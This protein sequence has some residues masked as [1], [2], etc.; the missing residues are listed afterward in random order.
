MK[1]RS[2]PV[3]DCSKMRSSE[4]FPVAIVDFDDY[5]DFVETQE[6]A[7]LSEVYYN[8]SI[9]F[10]QETLK[11]KQFNKLTC[12]NNLFEMSPKEILSVTEIL[13]NRIVQI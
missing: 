11:N 12:Q 2:V 13:K 3:S 10:L 7:E 9:E 5:K 4:L 1:I 8:E 6:I